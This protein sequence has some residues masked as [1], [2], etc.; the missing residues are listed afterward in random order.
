MAYPPG[1]PDATESPG[2]G[3]AVFDWRPLATYVFSRFVISSIVAVFTMLG[4]VW[5]IVE[6]SLRGLETAIGVTNQRIE[7]LDRNLNRRIED[8][9]RNLTKLISSEMRILKLELQQDIVRTRGPTQRTELTSPLDTARI[10]RMEITFEGISVRVPIRPNGPSVLSA[11]REQLRAWP[12]DGETLVV[13]RTA[14]GEP[15]F[16]LFSPREKIVYGTSKDLSLP[17]PEWK[18]GDATLMQVGYIVST[19]CIRE[20]IRENIEV[21]GNATVFIGRDGVA[22][23][24]KGS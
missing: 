18:M 1:R 10:E 3:L 21:E 2:S 24:G 4:G 19:P 8:L 23:R 15:V 9:D 14:R 17:S 11:L 7:D 20:L 16:A 12:E 22:C 6:F 5:L 13:A